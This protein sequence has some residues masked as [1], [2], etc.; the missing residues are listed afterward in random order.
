[1]PLFIF[2]DKVVTETMGGGSVKKRIYSFLLAVVILFSIMTISPASQQT[3][4]YICNGYAMIHARALSEVL[5]TEISWDN[6]GKY[7]VI[8]KHGIEIKIRPFSNDMIVNGTT[9]LMDTAAT[10]LNGLIYLPLRSI[11]EELG[12]TVSWN[13]QKKTV[14]VTMETVT[15]IFPVVPANIDTNKE[16]DASKPMIALT[17]DDGPSKYTDKILD[18]LKK[19][20]S[21]ATFFVLG[22]KVS[23]FPDELNRIIFEGSEIGN[24]SF[25][26][27]RFIHLSAKE[28]NYQIRNTQSEIYR[29]TGYRPVVYR[30]PYGEYNSTVISE[31]DMAAVLWN[32]DPKDWKYNDTSK[33]ISGVLSQAR[34]GRIVILHDTNYYTAAA[35]G[36]IVSELKKR[37]FQVVSV[38]EMFKA[39][40]IEVLPMKI[41]FSSYEVR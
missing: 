18:V 8:R 4:I 10:D 16:I 20:D 17:F 39:K 29:I 19:Y 22:C 41:Y 1:L 7:V 21:T 40:G 26:H 2:S 13:R 28:I 24:H 30:P 31:I 35:V 14:S 11:I 23:K 5:G 38:S 37:G 12:G 34:D 6:S 33:I 25:D 9:V 32:V 27:P 3:E 36:T 15:V